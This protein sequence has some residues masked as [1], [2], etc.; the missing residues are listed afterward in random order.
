M[1]PRC[2]CPFLYAS[3][4]LSLLS[5]H[6]K[7]IAMVVGCV[8]RWFVCPYLLF[9]FDCGPCN[10]P[11]RLSIQSVAV[12]RVIAPTEPLSVSSSIPYR[13]CNRRDE[14]AEHRNFRQQSPNLYSS[15]TTVTA[16]TAA[17]HCQPSVLVRATSVLALTWKRRKRRTAIK[18]S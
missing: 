9:P 7:M 3:L 16:A 5:G 4:S 11:P 18:G 2:C 17:V 10:L 14:R 13:S 15:S 1:G 8:L 12:A 6:F